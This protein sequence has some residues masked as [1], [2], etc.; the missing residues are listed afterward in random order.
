[1]THAELSTSSVVAPQFL[2]TV[3]VFFCFFFFLSNM[4]VEFWTKFKYESTRIS[5]INSE[6]RAVNQFMISESLAT[7]VRILCVP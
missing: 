6:F 2:W 4:G 3:T 7:C 1:M 5:P